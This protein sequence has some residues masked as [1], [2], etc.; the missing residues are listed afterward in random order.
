MLVLFISVALDEGPGPTIKYQY[1]E[2]T[3][4]YSVVSLLVRSCD[5]RT[6]CATKVSTALVTQSN[7]ETV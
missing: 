4:L 6:E 1:P 3:K 2:F 5:M 7:S